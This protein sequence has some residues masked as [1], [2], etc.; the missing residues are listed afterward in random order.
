MHNVDTSLIPNI[1]IYKKDTALNLVPNFSFENYSICPEGCTIIPKTYFVD[2]WMMATI[3]TPDYFNIC[4]NEAGIPNNWAGRIYPKT[5]NGCAGLIS[6][7][8]INDNGNIEEKREY[9]EAKL[10]FG[11]KKN[12]YYYLSFSASL[13]EKSKYATNGLGMYLSDT[14][15]DVQNY[16]SHLPFLPQLMNRNNEPVFE[17]YNWKE[18]NN[19]YKATGNEKYIIIGNFQSDDNTKYF[20]TRSYGYLNCTYYYIDDVYV[21]PLYNEKIDSANQYPLWKLDKSLTVIYFDF[22]K[23]KIKPVYYR[24]LDSLISVISKTSLLSIEVT[25]FTD[26]I[27]DDAYNIKLSQKRAQEVAVYFT[28]NNISL[29]MISENGFGY[30]FPVADNRNSKGRALNRRVEIK[31]CW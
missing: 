9:L 1:E 22:D 17:K 11:L 18:I 19:I 31:L 8:Y 26:N 23:W 12:C 30:N 15:V 4:S 3:G 5:G 29:K 13:A 14:L 7:M 27:G 20:E 25:G 16:I 10:K 28:K 2:D 21:L 24:K 6:G